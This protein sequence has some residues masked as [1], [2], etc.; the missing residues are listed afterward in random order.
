VFNYSRGSE[1]RQWDLHLHTASSYDYKYKGDDSDQLLVDSL[2]ANNIAAVA[3]TD[4]FIIDEVRINNLRHLAPDIVFFPG[5][6]LRT[7]KGASNGNLHMIL[8]FPDDT[9]IHTL[10][11]D[12]NSIMLR[13]KAKSGDSPQTIY[14]IFEHIVDFAKSNHGLISIHA[15]KKTSGI[16][17]VI[18]NALEVNQAIKADIAQ[19]V[20]FFEIGKISDIADYHKFVFKEIE[21]K[22]LILCSDCHDP[23]NYTRKEKLW[24][25]ADLTFEG[26]Q[27]AVLQPNERVFV[28]DMPPSLDRVEK[29]KQCYID[30]IC[31]S[32]K[33]K[34][35][36]SLETW[37]DFRLPINIGLTTVIGNKGSGKSALSDII[38]LFANCKS[39]NKA[40]FL[41]SDRFRK[42]PKNYAADYEGNLIWEDGQVDPVTNLSSS[43]TDITA[44]YAQYLPQ[45]YIEDVCNDLGSGFK[46]EINRVIFSYVDTTEK[47]AAGDLVELISQ[48]S[49]SIISQ[50][51]R[52]NLDLQSVNKRI[53]QLEDKK[54]KKYQLTQQNSLEKCQERLSRHDKNKPKSVDKPTDNIDPEYE[55]KIQEFDDQIKNIEKQIER[56]TS[57]LTAINSSVDEMATLISKIDSAQKGIVSLNSELSDAATKFGLDNLIISA[58]FETPRKMLDKRKEALESQKNE[59][60]EHLDSS[61]N[62]KSTSLYFQYAKLNADKKALVSTA[63]S[64]EKAY[65]KYQEDLKEWE[66]LRQQIIGDI[67]TPDTLEYYTNEV[68][69]IK[70]QLDTDYEKRLQ[71]RVDITRQIFVLKHQISDIYSSIYK[72]VESELKKLIGDMEDDN[73]EFVSELSLKNNEIGSELLSLIGKNYTG[74]FYG[75]TESAAKMASFI[76]QTD[77]NSWDSVM[78]FIN[79]VIQ[80]ITE[81]IDVSSSKVKNKEDFYEKLWGLEYIDAQYSLRMG[82]RTLDELSPGERGIVLLIFYLALSKDDIPLIIDQPED[83]L[84]N[85][86][87][88]NKLVK[89]ILEAKK[90]RQV[91]IVTHNPNIA[92][93][94]DSEEIVYCSINKKTNSITYESGSIEDPR[95]RNHVIDVL[96][97]T[98][99]AFDLRRRKYN[100]G[101]INRG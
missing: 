13:N 14:W 37:F 8:I 26:L 79:N 65:Q 101:I 83:N 1:W 70:S 17:D 89:C 16:D 81:D 61:D 94:C 30:T 28:G 42:L 58:D 52:L 55:T 62:A 22:P 77:F 98:M 39:M 46:D 97:G 19:D 85:Q 64:K 10:S 54:T 66:R 51:S 34:P 96:E 71:E 24:I 88:Y 95:M 76:K 2:R 50:I 75:V 80:V 84:D 21:E 48:K 73:I 99:P 27:Q 18:T 38:G 49:G 69:Y 15:G 35:V 56:K 87:V 74:I 60:K 20:D 78:A 29:N 7:D 90:K 91:I 63:D 36:N 59:L 72:P 82:G 41:N 86:S 45:K 93:A 67:N 9:D 11:A 3:I 68:K 33:S 53:I 6:E 4:H 23:K 32:R 57:D 12:F 47:G 40:S 31:V 92:V 25:K 44:E 5:V 43:R 100:T